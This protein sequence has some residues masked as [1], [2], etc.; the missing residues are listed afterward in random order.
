[1][2]ALLLVAAAAQAQVTADD[3]DWRE[4]EAPPPPTLQLQGLIP[5]EVAGS[6][7]RFGIAPASITVGED[8]IVRYIVVATSSSGVINAIYEG[9]RCDNGEFKVYARRN[10]AGG[11]NVVKDANWR[12]LRDQPYSLLIARSGACEGRAANRSPA[13]IV[14][15]LRTPLER[16]YQRD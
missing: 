8:G 11:W 10:A 15:D 7:L 3:P 14:R 12:P 6:A 16:R 1:M 9:I 5:L 2:G 4:A 13:R